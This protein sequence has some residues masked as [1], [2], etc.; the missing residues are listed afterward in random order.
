[1]DHSALK[2]DRRRHEFW[3]YVYDSWEYTCLLLYLLVTNL[4]V[5][6]DGSEGKESA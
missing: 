3:F 4:T 5:L 6:P 2:L 1:M